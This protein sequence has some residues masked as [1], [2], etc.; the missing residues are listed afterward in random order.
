MHVFCTHVTDYTADLKLN[1]INTSSS[2]KLNIT[3]KDDSITGSSIDVI[4]G[5]NCTG[6]IY[7]GIRW[8]ATNKQSVSYFLP[9]ANYSGDFC[10]N[11]TAVGKRVEKIEGLFF[12]GMVAI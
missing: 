6:L 12:Y 10:L 9:S 8:N 3:F 7:S 4:Y 11:L 1:I 5:P 2:A